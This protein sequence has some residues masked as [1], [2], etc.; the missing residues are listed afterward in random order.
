[1]RDVKRR[2][3]RNDSVKE[4]IWDYL[5]DNPDAAD[6][7]EGIVDWWIPQQELKT[8][9][10]RIEAALAKLVAKKCLLAQPGGDGRLHYRLHPDK[11]KELRKGATRKR[12]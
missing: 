6:T 11:K 1:M 12:L 10:T 2:V 7:L 4:M 9:A 5:K 3:S 8:S